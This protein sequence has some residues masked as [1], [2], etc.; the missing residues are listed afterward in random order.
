MHSGWRQQRHSAPGLLGSIAVHALALLAFLLYRDQLP[1]R[2]ETQPP[3]DVVFVPSPLSTAQPKAAAG[4]AASAE[5]PDEAVTLHAETMQPQVMTPVLPSPLPPIVAIPAAPSAIA[6][7]TDQPPKPPGTA[8]GS[9][10]RGIAGTGTG[11]GAGSGAG[12]I[13]EGA[14]LPPIWIKQ[15][16]TQDWADYYP[17][18]AR[19]VSGRMEVILSC[20]VTPKTRVQAC[21]LVDERPRGYGIGDAV[22]KM[23]KVFRVKP[24]MVGGQPRYDV[25]VGIRMVLTPPDDSPANMKSP[26]RG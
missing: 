10:A 16:T 3:L 6:P 8:T 15:A 4:G 11:P 25:R 18:T 9:T 1:G 19:S 20:L 23:S 21:R 26:F 5:Q 12:R 7:L 24:P 2:P 17:R 14:G 22:L 13:D